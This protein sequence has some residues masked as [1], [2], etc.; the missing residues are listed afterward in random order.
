MAQPPGEGR[1]PHRFLAK[2]RGLGAGYGDERLDLA[3]ESRAERF[4]AHVG[5]YPVGAV[6]LMTRPAAMR[7]TNEGLPAVSRPNRLRLMPRRARKLSMLFLRIVFRFA[8]KQER[9]G[10]IYY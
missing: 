4:L 10:N 3:P 1:I 2:Q 7:A 6:E 8:M 9:K 5:E